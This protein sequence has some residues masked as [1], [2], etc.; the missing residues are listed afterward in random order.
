MLLD[1]YS[2]TVLLLLSYFGQME[3]LDLQNHMLFLI[4]RKNV[5]TA[6]SLQESE[7]FIKQKVDKVQTI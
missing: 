6:N 4:L 2:T 5:R 1:T 3:T 7:L